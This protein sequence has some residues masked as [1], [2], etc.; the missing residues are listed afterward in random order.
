VVGSWATRVCGGGRGA[1]GTSKSCL[2]VSYVYVLFICKTPDLACVFNPVC[3]FGGGGSKLKMPPNIIHDGGFGG[4]GGGGEERV[5]MHLGQASFCLSA[6][7]SRGR[8]SG[9]TATL[10]S[11]QGRARYGPIFL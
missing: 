2:L 4:L 11:P 1:A 6:R 8:A 7:P 3:V 5:M 9:D 10:P